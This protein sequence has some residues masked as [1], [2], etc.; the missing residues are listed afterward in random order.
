MR[1]SF[2]LICTVVALLLAP[3]SAL[4]QDGLPPV[5]CGSLSDDDCAILEG[6]RDAMLAVTSYSSAVSMET[7]L[8][9]VPNLPAELGFSFETEGVFS[10]APDV[11]AR[12]LELQRGDPANL[13]DN[14]DELMQVTTDF[15]SESAFDLDISFALSEGLAELLSAQAG[16]PLPESL[17]M[18][19]RLVDGVVFVNVDE[20]GE[21][22]GDDEVSGWLGIDM[23]AAMEQSSAALAEQMESGDAASG[24]SMDALTG[25]LA[26]VSSSQAMAE[27]FAQYV[28]V[29]RLDDDEVDGVEVAQFLFTFDLAS[30][31]ASPEFIEM[32]SAQLE[33]QM[34]MQEAM[35]EE[36]PMTQEDL[37]M[38]VELLP[39]FAPMLLSGVQF[40]T[41][42]SVGLEDLFV[43]STETTVEWNL[44]QVAAMVE[45][46]MG[47]AGRPARGAENA[48]FSLYVSSQ[49]WGFDEEVEVEAPE[50]AMMVPLDEMSGPSM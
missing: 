47:G 34:A 6:S 10:L 50:G 37:D 25:A 27:Q 28:E 12:M 24:A 20:I 23:V 19:V 49:N 3:L 13:A 16:L 9:G 21:L 30:Y 8:E 2:L 22:T 5:T 41:V 39:M 40:E 44:S 43:Y 29:E 14:F 17:S 45:T 15:Y 32:I 11:N 1:K 4:A 42:K 48:F 38:V 35:G 26:S 33:Q 18:P 7:A 36:P 31:A 46:M